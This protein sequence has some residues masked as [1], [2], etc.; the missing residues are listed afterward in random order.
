[1]VGHGGYG[2]TLG[3]LAHGV[4]QV[5]LPLFSLDQWTNAVAVGRVG[6]GVGLGA[7]WPDRP[8]LSVP[9]PDDVQ[10]VAAAVASLLADGPARDGAR[11]IADAIAALP[12]VDAVVA[13][14]ESHA[15]AGL[16]S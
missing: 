1:V 10:A 4:P 9:G 16:R 13:V 12:P 15:G 14:L 2:T 6:A 7:D 3:A 8:A 5:I 11:R